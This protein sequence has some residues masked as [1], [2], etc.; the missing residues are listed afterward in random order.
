TCE[1]P[2][3]SGCAGCPVAGHTT[4]SACPV[5]AGKLAI[6]FPDGSSTETDHVIEVD[7]PAR[8]LMSSGWP[9]TTVEV[10]R[11]GLYS[12]GRPMRATS[13]RMV[14]SIAYRTLPGQAV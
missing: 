3:M 12:L 9:V 8:I 2:W 6:S 4:S 14:E 13:E 1:S 10:D 5:W 11:R 7:P